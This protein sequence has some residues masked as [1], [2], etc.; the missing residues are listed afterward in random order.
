MQPKLLRILEEK[1]FERVGGNAMIRSDFRVIAATNQNLEKKIESGEFRKDLFY[2]LNVIALNIPPLRDRREDIMPVAQYLLN[3]TA[4]EMDLTDIVFDSQAV[5]SLRGYDWP[6]NVRELSN[7]LERTLS[8]IE[9][10]TVR[11]EDLPFFI[12]GKQQRKA[13]D[14]RTTMKKLQEKAEKD[15]IL[16]C[17]E[18]CGYNK[19]QAAKMLGIHRTLLYRKIKKH[20]ILLQDGVKR[21]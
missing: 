4:D 15:T 17:L 1:E 18:E 5:K 6:G 16:S 13:T 20:G 11:L 10:K 7:V 21:L 12:S 2:R 3:K 14:V 8:R 19:T 9:G